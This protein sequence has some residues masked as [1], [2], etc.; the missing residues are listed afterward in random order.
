[1]IFERKR[2]NLKNSA[3]PELHEEAEHKEE[4]I[5]QVKREFGVYDAM[6]EIEK[7]ITGLKDNH[8]SNMSLSKLRLKK[9]NILYK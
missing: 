2:L 3:E 9:W 5:E 6:M 4:K 1:M 7:E 8:G